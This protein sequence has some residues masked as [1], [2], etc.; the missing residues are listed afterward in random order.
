MVP[1]R[2]FVQ[3]IPLVGTAAQPCDP[4]PWPK[5]DFAKDVEGPLK[6][7]I[8][9]RAKKVSDAGITGVMRQLGMKENLITDL[10]G[11]F[12]ERKLRDLIRK[13]SLDAIKEDLEKR[14]LLK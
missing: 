9:G 13:K 7:L 12:A 2:D 4:V 3:L 10:L 6:S 8:L 1:D 5:L 14:N 11:W